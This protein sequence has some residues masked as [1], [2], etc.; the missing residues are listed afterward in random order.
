MS[1]MADQLNLLALGHLVTPAVGK[2]N[3]SHLFHLTHVVEKSQLKPVIP[4]W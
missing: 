2:K 3:I 1:E 4:M